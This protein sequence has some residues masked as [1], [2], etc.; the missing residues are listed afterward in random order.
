MLTKTK[1][2][3]LLRTIKRFK[4]EFLRAS[5]VDPK[6][7]S[8]PEVMI[9]AVKSNGYALEYASEELRG[10]K[11]VVLEAVKE[12]GRALQFASYELRAD[13]DVVMEA[14]KQSGLALEFA[15]KFSAS[16]EVRGDED[17]VMEAVKQDGLALEF[18]SEEL[19]EKRNI[20]FEAMKNDL[21]A[22]RL[23]GRALVYDILQSLD[24]D[25][26]FSDPVDMP[27]VWE[28]V[29]NEHGWM[30]GWVR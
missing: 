23:F 9:A 20:A 16:Y 28:H 13:K 22:C 7:L 21:A 2:I 12:N 26:G 19:K 29:L 24:S 18:A 6:F 25:D 14:V 17:V 11:E 30:R 5:D 27:P 10:D 3:K 15:T 4:P 8:D 1:L